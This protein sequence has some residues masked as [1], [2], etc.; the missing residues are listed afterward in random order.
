MTDPPLDPR[1]NLAWDRSVLTFASVGLALIV[2]A[3]HLGP[4][5]PATGWV[6][7]A[8]AACVAMTGIT[9]RARRRVS[10]DARALLAQLAATTAALGIVAFVVALLG[11]A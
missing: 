3:G 8:I 5:R 9:Y 4:A 11:P 7:L 6:I 2:R 1:E 10:A